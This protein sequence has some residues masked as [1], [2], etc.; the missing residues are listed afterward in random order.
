MKIISRT[1]DWKTEEQNRY[2]I[3]SNPT[4]RGA[5]QIIDRG[6][7][8]DG[9]HPVLFEDDFVSCVKYQSDHNLFEVL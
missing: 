6:V 4:P 7:L 1:T 5:F 2:Q 9:F 3:I 8:R